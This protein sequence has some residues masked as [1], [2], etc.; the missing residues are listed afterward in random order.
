ME[1]YIGVLAMCIAAGILSA[2]VHM[3]LADKEE[4]SFHIKNVYFYSVVFYGAM[5]LMKAAVGEG[6]KTLFSAFNDMEA[7]TYIHYGV[8]LII[9]A[10]ALPIL[11]KLVLGF[12]KG[13]RFIGLFLSIFSFIIGLEF[14]LWGVISSYNYIAVCI[15]AMLL[16][17]GILF[18]YKGEIRFFA[19]ENAKARAAFILPILLLW[20]VIVLIFEPNQL[21][22]NN[23]DE[24]SIPYF[25][26]FG[27]MLAEGAAMAAVYTVICV[28]VLSD[29]Q[30][31]LFG[32]IIF[33]ISAAGYIQGNFLNG[34]M[35]LMD[36]NVQTWS[37]VQKAIN[38]AAWIIMLAVAAYLNYNRRFKGICRKIVSAVCVYICLVQLLSLVFMIASAKFPDEENE[39]VLTTNHMLELDDENNVVVFVLDWFDRQIM[40]DIEEENPDFTEALKD[41]TEYTDTTSRY[42]FTALSVPYLLTGVEWEYGMEADEY[43]EYA[44]GNGNFLSDIEGQNYSLGVYTGSR[45]VGDAVKEK[46]INYSNEITREIGIKKAFYVMSDTSKYKMAPFAAKQMYFYTT[47][48]IAEIVVNSGE[49]TANNDIVFYNEL[50]QNKLSI[51]ESGAYEGAFRF[52]HLKGAHPQFTMNENFEEVEGD[53]GTQLSQ[54]KGSLKIVY[55]YIDEMKKLGVY[56]NATIIITADHGQNTNVMKE[57]ALDT[58]Y[59]MTSTPILFVKLP[60]EQHDDGPAKSSAQVSHTDFA[61]T[62]INAVGGNP[63][64]Y[65]RTFAE[66]D[67]DEVRDRVFTYV[68]APD[69]KYARYVITG[70]SNNPEAW[71]EAAGDGA[72]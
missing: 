25:T 2:L 24:F 69:K 67:E 66:I 59:D 70:D 50:S 8:P 46:L 38:G 19:K 22:L 17:F 20:I 5:S 43:C 1:K 33:G 14:L 55:Q 52:Y 36:G 21:L 9:M 47:D 58:D 44:Y 51:D 48:D 12:G 57:S 39:F 30:L 23:L 72:D 11:I 16:S 37:S 35:L 15:A 49:Y 6:G 60:N 61:A 4:R 42:A 31:K 28:F 54:S 34:E 29:R 27:I 68:V 45:H 10:L 7:L 32:T 71:R 41:F 63:A 13:Q 53:G 26:F 56:D 40:D 18:F 62:V 3:L 64:E 65:G